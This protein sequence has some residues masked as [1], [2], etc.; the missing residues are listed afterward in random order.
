MQQQM[1]NQSQRMGMPVST[2][3]NGVNKKDLQ[4]QEILK[5]TQQ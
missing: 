2:P 3:Q 4:L 1:I 5:F